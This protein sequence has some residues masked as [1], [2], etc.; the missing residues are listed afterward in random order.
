M[1]NKSDRGIAVRYLT[2]AVTQPSNG[3]DFDF[4]R[5]PI[6]ADASKS[7]SINCVVQGLRGPLYPPSNLASMAKARQVTAKV[8]NPGPSDRDLLG[9]ESIIM[10]PRSLMLAWLLTMNVVFP[11]SLPPVPSGPTAVP[12]GDADLT[13]TNFT[14]IVGRKGTA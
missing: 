1:G 2:S 8:R 9:K 4:L 13:V 3:S 14:K 11:A 7:P 5:P 10:E 12:Y 6:E